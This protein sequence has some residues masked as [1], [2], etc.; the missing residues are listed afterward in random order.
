MVWVTPLADNSGSISS[1]DCISHCL[2]SNSSSTGSKNS[3]G[4][5]GCG[6]S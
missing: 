4:G 5:C 2:A 1:D 6:K 3:G